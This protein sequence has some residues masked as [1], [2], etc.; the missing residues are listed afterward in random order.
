MSRSVCRPGWTFPS[1]F[2]SARLA[3]ERAGFS[4]ERVNYLC[5]SGAIPRAIFHPLVR[6]WFVPENWRID[7]RLR[8]VGVFHKV[9]R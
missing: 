8:V 6:W 3:A 1:G 2:V 5:E 7:A 4:W 9:A